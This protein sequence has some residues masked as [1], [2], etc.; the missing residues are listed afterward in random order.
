MSRCLFCCGGLLVRPYRQ[1]PTRYY[2]SSSFLSI[3]ETNIAWVNLSKLLVNTVCQLVIDGRPNSRA[4]QLAM[5]HV[6]QRISDAVRPALA[7]EKAYLPQLWL[8]ESG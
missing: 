7:D 3:I 6:Q 5:Q 8:Q 1:I 4:R 2:G